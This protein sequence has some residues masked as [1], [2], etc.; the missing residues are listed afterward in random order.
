MERLVKASSRPGDL[1]Y[2][3]FLGTGTSLKVAAELGRNVIGC[4][5]DE[6][7][8]LAAYRRVKSVLPGIKLEYEYSGRLSGRSSFQA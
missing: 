8:L 2:D 6:A 4:E 3:P 1:V 5:S 7:M